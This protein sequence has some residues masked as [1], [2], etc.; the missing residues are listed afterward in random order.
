MQTNITTCTETSFVPFIFS[1]HFESVPMQACLTLPGAHFQAISFK[2]L[3]QGTKQGVHSE[4]VGAKREW[5]PPDFL[6][7]LSGIA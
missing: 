3:R 4:F 7:I 1:C 6:R 2:M 5:I